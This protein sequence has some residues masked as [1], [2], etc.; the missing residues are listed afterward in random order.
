MFCVDPPGQTLFA[1]FILGIPESFLNP[2]LVIMVLFQ[3][4]CWKYFARPFF[5]NEAE[6]R[7]AI[8]K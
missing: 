5:D 1:R 4:M 6:I 3:A 2:S 8:K 7:R